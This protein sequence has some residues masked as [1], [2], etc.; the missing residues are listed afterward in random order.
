MNQAANRS[1]IMRILCKTS[2]HFSAKAIKI[3]TSM[4]RM[5]ARA[6]KAKA[7]VASPAIVTA[8]QKAILEYLNRRGCLFLRT[9]YPSPAS[10]H[11]KSNTPIMPSP[12]KGLGT[13]KKVGASIMK[14]QTASAETRKA[15]EDAIFSISYLHQ[16]YSKKGALC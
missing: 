9:T 2:R 11:K 5:F 4:P 7:K 14:T 12:V 3:T 8:A 16:Q 6:Y 13:E 10:E 15:T 1:I